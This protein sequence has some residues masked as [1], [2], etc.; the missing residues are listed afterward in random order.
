MRISILGCGHVGL[1][2]GA[3][4]AGIGHEIVCT[5]N[6]QSKIE[7][8]KQGALPFY[9][10]GLEEIVRQN[11]ADRRLSFTADITEAVRFGDTIFICVGTPPLE[12]GDADLSAMDE[13]ARLIVG[14]AD[15][16]KLVVQKSTVPTHTG[17]KLKQALAVYAR[18]S[19]S[20]YTFSVA[21]NP[22]FLREGSAVLDFLH[23][24]R[25]VIGVEAEAAERQLRD[26]Y[27]PIL[28]QDFPCQ[29]HKG[30]CPP[31]AAPTLLVTSINSAELIKHACNTFLAMKISYANLI[32]DVCEV[33]GADVEQVM[34]AMGFDPRI[35]PAFL[36]PGLGFGG[37]CLP[38]DIQ[39]FSKV[40]ERAGV[41]A[42]LLNAVESINKRRIDHFLKKVRQSLWVIKHKRIGVLGLSFK[43]GTD[44]VR[45]AP[46]LE[47]IR[48]LLQ[49]HA[50]VQAY[51]P[52]AKENARRELPM[53]TYC[54]S[55]YETASGAEA[56]IIAT[57]WEEFACLDWVRVRELMRRPLVLDGRN[58]LHPETMTALG[59]EYYDIGRVK[60]GSDQPAFS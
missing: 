28:D 41:D 49:E 17:Q 24:D 36:H 38:K 33:M 60:Q 29:V 22:E 6:D 42:S 46:A 43:P 1:V 11:V 34:N 5:D 21:S 47:L 44:D 16:A 39:A 48:R 26:V 18:N 51:D 56:L 32:G 27:G 19:R 37:F 52:R 35:G 10:P 31:Q 57:E 12:T 40:A 14:A 7:L 53:I 8:L 55:A 50:E 20:P 13:A 2:T 9:E 15:S 23:P 58:L 4:L 59:F 3:C 45:F 30:Q 25:V 54:D